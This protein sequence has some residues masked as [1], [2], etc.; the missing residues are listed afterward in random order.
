M[1]FAIPPSMGILWV[2]FISIGTKVVVIIGTVV[3]GIACVVVV[4]G[5]VVLEISKV[6]SS[7]AVGSISS[8]AIPSVPLIDLLRLRPND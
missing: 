6:F 5:C 7:S 3:S 2:A 4:V 1:T 8:E